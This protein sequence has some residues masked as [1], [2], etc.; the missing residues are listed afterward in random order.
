[1]TGVAILYVE[2]YVLYIEMC[3]DKKIYLWTK[4]IFVD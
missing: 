3:M 2:K 1:M 4:N